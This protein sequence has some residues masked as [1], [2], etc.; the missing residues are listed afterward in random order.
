VIRKHGKYNFPNCSISL[1]STKKCGFVFQIWNCVRSQI[2]FHFL[3]WIERVTTTTKSVTANRTIVLNWIRVCQLTKDSVIVFGD[4][5]SNWCFD[6]RYRLSTP[7]TFV[8]LQFLSIVCPAKF[9]TWQCHFSLVGDCSLLSSL[10]S[11]VGQI[12]SPE[13]GTLQTP[14]FWWFRREFWL[15]MGVILEDSK[16]R[17]K[18]ISRMWNCGAHTVNIIPKAFLT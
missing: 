6:R 10:T 11:Q 9:R 14:M 1:F 2:L 16:F 17:W 5:E 3:K 7:D 13:H 18:V 8:S 12:C 4:S 15:E